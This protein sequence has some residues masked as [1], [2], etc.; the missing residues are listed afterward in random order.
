MIRTSE[1]IDFEI[2]LLL[3]AIFFKYRSDFRHYSIASVR[4]R[5]SLAMG[6]FGLESV[7]QLQD[8]VLED[9]SFYESLLQY[10]TVSTTEMFRDPSFF[11][12]LR[13]QVLPVLAT[14]PSIKIWIA[15]CS[16]GEELYSTAILLKEESLLHRTILY[17]TDINPR[18]LAAAERGVFSLD[19]I[20]K[21]TGNYQQS[22]GRA[23]FSDYYQVEGN[24]ALFHP[25]LRANVVFADHS[26]A[27]DSVFTEAQLVSCRNVLIYFDR[28]L[29]DRALGLFRDSLSHR[30]FLALGSKESIRFS[31][32]S[33]SFNDFSTKEKIYR[34]KGGAA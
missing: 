17:A 27:T 19:L 25:D 14:Y 6:S 32:V 22:G 31:S 11:L 33:N 34:L 1:T 16:T 18:S 4:R 8:R 30:G 5:I 21:F 9:A 15:G 7:S 20:K 13:T 28:E 26:L 23:A 3:E 29:Q 12:A 10:L 2:K 24:L